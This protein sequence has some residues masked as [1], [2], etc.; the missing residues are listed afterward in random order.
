MESTIYDKIAYINNLLPYMDK[1]YLVNILKSYKEIKDLK[2]INN[3]FEIP[4]NIN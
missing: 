3:A 4:S 2:I 1:N